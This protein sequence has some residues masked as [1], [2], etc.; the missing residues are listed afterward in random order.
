MKRPSTVRT[1]L[2][3]IAYTLT[4]RLGCRVITLGSAICSWA[5][6]RRAK[7]LLAG[8]GWQTGRREL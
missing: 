2:A 4:H 8:T 7:V 5:S 6:M 3:I 1:D